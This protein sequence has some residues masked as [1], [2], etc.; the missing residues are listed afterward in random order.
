MIVIWHCFA[1]VGEILNDL[2]L[3]PMAYKNCTI[4]QF[5]SH[6][7]I[8]LLIFSSFLYIIVALPLESYQYFF[9]SFLSL[10]LLPAFIFTLNF[11]LL[12]FIHLH[13]SSFL[14]SAGRYGYFFSSLNLLSLLKDFSVVKY[15]HVFSFCWT[16]LQLIFT[17]LVHIGGIWTL[18]L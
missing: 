13:S 8:V 4:R 18:M 7:I 2:F 9:R 12:I 5:S 17:S 1:I 10:Y 11:L 3:D 6:C 16:F 14:S 15:E